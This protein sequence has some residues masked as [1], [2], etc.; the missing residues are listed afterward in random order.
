MQQAAGIGNHNAVTVAAEG[1][2]API[3]NWLDRN[4]GYRLRA[5]LQTLIENNSQYIGGAL[6]A[7]A[8]GTMARIASVIGAWALSRFT[9]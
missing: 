8:V 1:M 7:S 3:L 6:V 2:L 4:L 5:P 9:N